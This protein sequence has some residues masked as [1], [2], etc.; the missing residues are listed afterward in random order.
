M[1]AIK[2]DQKRQSD[3]NDSQMDGRQGRMDGTASCAC[4]SSKQAETRL[5]QVSTDGTST[6]RATY[7]DCPH[8]LPIIPDDLTQS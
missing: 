5:R 6:T 3:G 1:G 2:R 8:H 4:Y 7:L